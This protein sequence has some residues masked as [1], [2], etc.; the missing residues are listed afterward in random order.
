[1]RAQARHLGLGVDLEA[2][3]QALGDERGDI[4]LGEAA[5]QQ[6]VAAGSTIASTAANAVFICAMQSSIHGWCTFSG[7]W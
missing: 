4:G 5:E 1:M 7:G 6:I 3:R 2:A